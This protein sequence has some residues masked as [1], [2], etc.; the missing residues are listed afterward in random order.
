MTFL[1]RA[2]WLR[3]A[4][5]IAT[6]A[7]ASAAAAQVSPNDFARGFDVRLTSQQ[8]VA[9]LILPEPVY[10]GVVRPDLR[11]LRVFNGAGEVVPHALRRVAEPARREADAVDVPVFPLRGKPGESGASTR[12]SVA[13]GGA[14]VN[15][16][17]AQVAGDTVVAY[18][19]DVSRLDVPLAT[20]RLAWEAPA[21]RTFLVRVNVDGSG[22]LA[23][24]SSIAQAAPVARLLSGDRE[25]AQAEVDLH[26]QRAKYV[27]V[28]WPADL[29]G[30][31][32][33]G[34][35][36]TPQ[37]E[38][39]AA[40]IAWAVRSGV[41]SDEVRGAV[42][43]DTGGALPVERLALEF[44]DANEV[45]QV[46]LFARPD[47]KAPWRRVADG[48]F[49]SVTQ[50]G[51]TVTSPPLPIA[52]ASDR[53]WRVEVTKD[54][55]WPAGRL[56]RV[57]FGW[58]PHEL[59][60]LVRGSGPFTLAYGSATVDEATAPLDVV[61]RDRDGRPIADRVQAAALGE[62]RELGGQAALTPPRPWR[63]S[64][65]WAV[66]GLAVVALA[67]LALRAAREMG[68]GPAN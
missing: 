37:A 45:A 31:R 14:V 57:R 62:A 28:S 3:A 18:L 11:D 67:V 33:T 34:A 61:L 8:P 29:A 42:E 54:G 36:I 39:P 9:Q 27:R 13:V 35:R 2:C 40:P 21:D 25:L 7:W 5:A 49:Y 15:V 22:D 58:Y 66:L 20:L 53:F 23:S 10:M 41:A 46:T 44:V 48:A 56:P 6:V 52:P 12:V 26:G 68:R 47:E 64:A 63:Q 59:L 16:Q 55:G 50:N 43:F 17:D 60:F 30:V 65:L 1:S 19:L 38:A 51:G 24:W 4:M 32:L